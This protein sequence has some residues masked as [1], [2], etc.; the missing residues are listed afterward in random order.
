M[1]ACAGAQAI[2]ESQPCAFVQSGRI[3]RARHSPAPF[4]EDMRVNHRGLDAG[5]SEQF[6]NGSDVIAVFEQVRGEGVPEGCDR[7]S[8]VS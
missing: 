3:Q 2:T 4:V 8:A 7:Q 5:V 1:I 6:L